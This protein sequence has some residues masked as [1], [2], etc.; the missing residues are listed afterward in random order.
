MEKIKTAPAPGGP[1]HEIV[2]FTWHRRGTVLAS[3]GPLLLPSRPYLRPGL[4]I[5]FAR[6]TCSFIRSSRSSDM[7]SAYTYKSSLALRPATRNCLS[8]PKRFCLSYPKRFCLTN[9]PRANHIGTIKPFGQGHS[10]V[11]DWFRP[12]GCHVYASEEMQYVPPAGPRRDTG[13]R[14]SG[15]STHG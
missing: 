13:W 5:L 2:L 4:H 9:L 10:K 15:R 1:L 3:E 6:W 11:W 12:R 14:S 7:A 8:Y